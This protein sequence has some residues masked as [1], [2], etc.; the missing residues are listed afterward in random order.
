MNLMLNATVDAIRTKFA[1]LEPVLNERARRLWAAVEARAIGRGGITRVAE[2][3]GLSRATIRAGLK[4]LDV[5][6]PSPGRSETT[7]ERIRRL[8]GGRKT[9]V[10]HD[11][12]LLHALATLVDPVTRG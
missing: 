9:L 5:P 11:P 6:M 10:D 4:Q 7:P 3:T 8:G 12:K 1:A 2:A